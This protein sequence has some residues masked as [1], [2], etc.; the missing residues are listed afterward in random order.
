M[1][2]R[3]IR[4]HKIRPTLLVALLAQ[5]CATSPPARPLPALPPPIDVATLLDPAPEPLIVP[6]HI[7]RYPDVRVRKGDC[8]GQPAGILVSPAVYAELHDRV[9]QGKRTAAELEA[10]TRLR[11]EER[12]AAER[13]EVAYRERLAEAGA[14]GST[15]WKTVAVG[16]FMGAVGLIG[17]SILTG[18]AAGR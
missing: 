14:D 8:P 7:P 10:L 12:A 11:K 13:L 5:A 4:G 15:T 9:S 16:L 2:D 6:A 1:I 18:R 3:T 17:G